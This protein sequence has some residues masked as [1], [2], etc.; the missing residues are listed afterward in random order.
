MGV[1]PA[2]AVHPQRAEGTAQLGM[3]CAATC[4]L[5]QHD[6]DK[7]ALQQAQFCDSFRVLCTCPYRTQGAQSHGLGATQQGTL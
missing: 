3:Q 1:L 4:D 7:P 5:T 6:A 2:Q